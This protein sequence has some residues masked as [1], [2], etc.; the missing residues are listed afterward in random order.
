LLVGSKEN[1][2]DVNED[3]TKYM[4]M[5]RDQIAGRIYKIKTDSSSFEMVEDFKYLG[6]T[7]ANQKSIQEEIKSRLR[8]GNACYHSVQNLCLPGC[9][10]KI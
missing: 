2:L 9:Y 7:L 8:L 3:K 4:A 1:G 5:S 10:P 6:R